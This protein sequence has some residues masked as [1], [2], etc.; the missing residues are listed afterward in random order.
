MAQAGYG[1]ELPSPS[2]SPPSRSPS[3]RRR[4]QLPEMP[5]REA[6][7]RGALKSISFF[8]A[9]HDV[10]EHLRADAGENQTV[11]DK[12]AASP[13]FQ[14]TDTLLPYLICQRAAKV[15]VAAEEK[16]KLFEGGPA[17]LIEHGH[18]EVTVGDGPS[19][20]LG[21]GELLNFVGMLELVHEAAPFKPSTAALSRTAAEQSRATDVGPYRIYSPGQAPMSLFGE[22]RHG[23]QSLFQGP[24]PG[25]ACAE[26]FL[27][28]FNLCPQAALKLNPPANAPR[29]DGWLPLKVRGRPCPVSSMPEHRSEVAKEDLDEDEDE[30]CRTADEP[31]ASLDNGGAT[32]LAIDMRIVEEAGLNLGEDSEQAWMLRRS[33]Q[34]FKAATK[35]I[36]DHW[37]SL[38]SRCSSVFVGVPPEVMWALAETV[39]Y[40]EVLPGELF[41]REGDRGE[42]LFLI[43]DG[44]ADVEKSIANGERACPV[45]L[46]QLGP[47]ALIGDLGL[48]G[49]GM[50]RPCS[51]R[52]RSLVELLR[53][54]SAG[55]YSVLRRFPG[56][57][58]ALLPR[59]REV[60][61]F[62]QLRLPMSDKVFA[63]LDLFEDGEPGLRQQAAANSKRV[64]YTIGQVVAD[65]SVNGNDDTLYVL[66]RGECCM[67]S[68]GG[69]KTWCHATSCFAVGDTM[70]GR[71]THRGAAVKVA[72]PYA[73]VLELRSKE[74]QEAI[75]RHCESVA[76]PFSAEE[77]L[78]QHSRLSSIVRSAEIFSK[79]SPEFVADLAESLELK[80][81]MPGQTLAVHNGQ[82]A[83]QM[84]LLRGGSLFLEKNEKRSVH[85]SSVLGELVMLGATHHREN[86]FRAQTFCFTAEITRAAF[87]EAI[88]RFP[89]ERKHLESYAM[90]QL[91]KSSSVEEETI[92]WP[93]QRWAPQR[94]GYLLNLFAGRAF[95]DR[96]DLDL[97]LLTEQCAILLISGE[98]SLVHDDGRPTEILSS[99]DCYNEQILLGIPGGSATGIG[100]FQV[101]T[102]VCELQCVSPKI[103]EKVISEFPTEKAMVFKVIQDC[104]ADKAAMKNQG[105]SRGSAEIVRMSGL[106]RSFSD[107]AIEAL[108]DK[109]ESLV[110]RPETQI[111]TKGKRNQTLYILLSGTVYVEEGKSFRRVEYESGKVWGEAELLGVSKV[112]NSTIKSASTCILQSMTFADFWKVMEGF[113]ADCELVE[114]LC[115]EAATTDAR[116]LRERIYAAKGFANSAPDLV[117][118]I[119]E[120]AEDAFFAPGEAVITFGDECSF[121]T[122]D[123]FVLLA[124]DAVVETDLGVEQARLRPGEVFGE[125]GA[126]GFAHTRVATVRAATTGCLHCAVLKG[127]TLYQAF[128]QYPQQIDNFENLLHERQAEN[129]EFM[130][131]RNKWLEEKVVP[132]LAATPLFHKCCSSFLADVAAPL[133]S[134]TCKAGDIIIQKAAPADSM[135]VVLEGQAQ[136]EAQDGSPIG[137]YRKG[138]SLGEMVA[139][140]LFGEYPA[141]IRAMT[142]CRVLMVTASALRRALSL[143]HRT[144]TERQRFK[145]IVAGR[146]GQVAHGLPMS[147]LPISIAEDDLCAEAIALQAE[148][149]LLEPGDC[150]N[151]LPDDT[152]WGAAFA[153][154]GDGRGLLELASANPRLRRLGGVDSSPAVP[155]LSLT[156]GSLILEGLAA[157]YGCRVRAL[158]ALKIYRVRYVDFDVSV[159]L[160]S[161][162]QD[163]LARFRMLESDIRIQLDHRGGSARGVVDALVVHPCD[164]D[165]HK[166]RA[167]RQKAIGLSRKTKLQLG[168]LM[169]AVPQDRSVQLPAASREQLPLRRE[170]S[171]PELSRQSTRSRD[172]PKKLASPCSVYSSVG[173]NLSAISTALSSPTG[174]VRLPSI[175]MR[176]S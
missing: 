155:V 86:T 73:M 108:R 49:S 103:W 144:E 151:P 117:S 174:S 170:Q 112:N 77:P 171:A 122:C 175:S 66:E 107:Q 154:V 15:K 2:S 147:A 113:P 138:A 13:I 87:L 92:I 55:I 84:F 16:L 40:S 133:I 35:Q 162:S 126:L 85:D 148:E 4:Q 80:S 114:K 88:Q 71:A 158:S 152:P 37:R 23:R 9:H 3:H 134:Q 160:E 153:V 39:E 167:R 135:L 44:L 161:C 156:T 29:R 76:P 48:I 58:G 69:A 83:S 19:V 149:F 53:I 6:R 25:Q 26:D 22:Q 169:A 95:Y 173:A 89:Q 41:I 105:C 67:E 142:D 78:K 128:K 100:K 119:C 104:M 130:V 102:Q 17:Y 93:M 14:R 150:W 94:L 137:V 50:P 101:R 68:P 60:G 21:P 166:Y 61:A 99:G 34:V 52:A 62:M 74:L 30:E 45:V 36:T 136:V 54:P 8:S 127:A 106:L 90:D 109:F 75:S 116:C 96:G 140:S 115:A 12:L 125:A 10:F 165:L 163:W 38:V 121:G 32:V 143:P 124:G 65:G 118:V 168:S 120:H 64:L 59:M 51:A 31:D 176:S 97:A 27:C 129:A 81:Y 20:L 145:N 42:D 157:A 159:S 11:R 111:V 164:D 98:A 172:R 56:M 33:L 24:K 46:G 63:C 72:S 132:A 47:G 131:R 141:T 18:L 1:E 70:A 5:E 139:L 28:F 123:M 43:D 7:Q 57:L 79:C 110:V 82:D 146:R 91:H